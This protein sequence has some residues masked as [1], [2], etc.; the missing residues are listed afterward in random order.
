L[1][2]KKTGMSWN[3]LSMLFSLS[4]LNLIRNVQVCYTNILFTNVIA[5]SAVRYGS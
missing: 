3:K 2:L 1:L 4:P 5:A